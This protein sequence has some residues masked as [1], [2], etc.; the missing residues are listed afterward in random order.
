MSDNNNDI[1]Y[2]YKYSCHENGKR[3]SIS[4]TTSKDTKR[5]VE[6]GLYKIIFN[7]N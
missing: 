4:F 1:Y 6:E 3:V 5:T 2:C 7:D